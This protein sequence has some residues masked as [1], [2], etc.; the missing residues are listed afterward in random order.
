M[1]VASNSRQI[2]GSEKSGEAAVTGGGATSEIDGGTRAM[3]LFQVIWQE[4]STLRVEE[5]NDLV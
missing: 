1:A 4:G 5:F 2:V 3:P